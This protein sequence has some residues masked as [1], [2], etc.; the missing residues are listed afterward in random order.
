MDQLR[1]PRMER[2]LLYH[3]WQHPDLLD[4]QLHL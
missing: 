3:S 2:Y 1:G 4:H